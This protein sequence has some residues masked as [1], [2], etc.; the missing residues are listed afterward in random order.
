MHPN[1]HVDMQSKVGKEMQALHD[2]NS[3]RSVISRH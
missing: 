2:I 1:N 3:D